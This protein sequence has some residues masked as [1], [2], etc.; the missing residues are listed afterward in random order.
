MTL[1]NI[2]YLLVSGTKGDREGK[3]K[4]EGK[5]EVR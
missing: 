1:E 5:D 4:A 2:N 3:K